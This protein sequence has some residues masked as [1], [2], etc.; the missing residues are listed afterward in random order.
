VRPHQDQ[1]TPDRSHRTPRI[2]NS[3]QEN[4]C[5]SLGKQPNM[6]VIMSDLNLF[7][8]Y[9][10]TIYKAESAIALEDQ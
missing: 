8:E 2:E 4:L 5:S 7:N 9:V 1:S 6:L 3:Y 10:L